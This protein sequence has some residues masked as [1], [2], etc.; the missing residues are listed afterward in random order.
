M[1]GPFYF[2]INL[3][4]FGELRLQAERE[5]KTFITAVVFFVNGLIS[6]IAGWIYISNMAT[7]R[8]RTGRSFTMT[9]NSNW[10][11]SKPALTIC[12]ATISTLG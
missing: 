2:K 8:L 6:M 10:N 11:N 9:P 5:K 4:K 7:L 12:P 3:N 1:T